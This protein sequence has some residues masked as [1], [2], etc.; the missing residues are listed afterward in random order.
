MCRIYV[1]ENKDTG[2]FNIHM[3][4]GG[5]NMEFI[6]SCFTEESVHAALI[7]T[8]DEKLGKFLSF[9]DEIVHTETYGNGIYKET[10]KISVI[11][12]LEN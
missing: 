7:T 10:A 12:Y 8:I 2:E 4:T 5:N 11:K 9:D 1:D 6:E 3:E